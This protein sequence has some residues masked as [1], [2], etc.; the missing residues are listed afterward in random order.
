MSVS[1]VIYECKT[2]I[3]TCRI[4]SQKHSGSKEI[5]VI[6]E[7]RSLDVLEE[8]NSNFEEYV[9]ITDRFFW[10]QRMIYHI[11]ALPEIVS[12]TFLPYIFEEDQVLFIQKDHNKPHSMEDF[13]APYGQQNERNFCSS[14]FDEQMIKSVLD[15][16][17]QTMINLIKLITY[18]AKDPHTRFFGI[19]I[20]N[21]SDPNE[22]HTRGWY[23]V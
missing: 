17:E 7:E 11:F 21:E 15:F 10:K 6:N 1:I 23:K 3:Q 13:Y 8:I 4:E 12:A 22:F 14:I 5:K 2:R 19:T 16:P 20:R 9:E 18:F